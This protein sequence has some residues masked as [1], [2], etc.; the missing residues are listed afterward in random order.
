MLDSVSLRFLAPLCLLAFSAPPTPLSAFQLGGRPAEEWALTLESG[1]RLGNLEIDEVV[2][3]MGLRSGD[4][5]A[6]VGAGTGVFS[7]SLARAVGP[8]GIVLAVEV[9]A[10]FL[11]MIEQKAYDGG[12]GNIQTVLGEFGDPKLPRRDIDVAFFHDVVHH[13]EGRQAYFQTTARYMAPGS[14]IVVVD[15]H[16]GHPN[17]PHGNQ[18]E[19]QITLPQVREWLSVAGYDMTQEFDLFEEKFFV[20]FTK[21]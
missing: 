7:V 14:R 4:V 10:G 11:P 16:G 1:R 8:T 3:R 20:V 12:L 17:A 2:S 9:D 21:R 15:Y 6:D 13:I 18:P 5:V 19:L